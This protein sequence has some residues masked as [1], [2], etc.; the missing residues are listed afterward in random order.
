MLLAGCLF[1]LRCAPIAGPGGKGGGKGGGPTPVSAYV[2]R[3]SIKWRVKEVE[4]TALLHEVAPAL[5]DVRAQLGQGQSGR[6]SRSSGGGGGGAD[7]GQEAEA[8]VRVA[9]GHAIRKLKGHWRL[10]ALLAPLVHHPACDPPLGVER[11]SGSGGRGGGGADG[12]T[13]EAAAAAAL[14]SAGQDGEVA[15]AAEWAA[16]HAGAVKEIVAAAHAFG[17]EDCWQWKPLLDGKEVDFRGPGALAAVL[18][19]VSRTH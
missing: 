17:L 10:G 2:I 15:A 16:A 12:G 11:V 4:G 6:P 14:V 18:W 19:G 1:P 3:E 7:G 9:L 5:E 8:D 13:P